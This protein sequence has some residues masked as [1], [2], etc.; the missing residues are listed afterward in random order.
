MPTT[1]HINQKARLQH[2]NYKSNECVHSEHGD[3][4]TYCDLCQALCLCDC[5]DKR[6]YV[7]VLIDNKDLHYCLTCGAL[8]YHVAQ[9]DFWHAAGDEGDV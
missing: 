4:P 5:H 3:C 7:K 1:K 8:V 6:T 2:N 9:H